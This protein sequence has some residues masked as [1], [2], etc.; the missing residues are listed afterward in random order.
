[1]IMMEVLLDSSMF[2]IML[3]WD[4][5]CSLWTYVFIT[6]F[7]WVVG[8]HALSSAVTAAGETGNSQGECHVDPSSHI[9]RSPRKKNLNIWYSPSKKDGPTPPKRSRGRPQKFHPDRQCGDCT[10]W[11]QLG[12]LEHLKAAHSVKSGVKH[13]EEKYASWQAWLLKGGKNIDLRF[14]S[15]LCK[16]C[17]S[18]CRT[19]NREKP[20][21]YYQLHPT[22]SVER[23]CIVCHAEATDSPSASLCSCCSTKQ[24]APA[25]WLCKIQLCVFEKCFSKL[26]NVPIYLSSAEEK[27]LC[28]KHFVHYGRLE[29]R[30]RCGVCTG[31]SSSTWIHVGSLCTDLQ[32]FFTMTQRFKSETPLCQ[33]D[34]MCS[35]CSASYT[36]GKKRHSKSCLESDLLSTN[37]HTKLKAQTVKEGLKWL[38]QAGH[39]MMSKLVERY[40]DIMEA[41]PSCDTSAVLQEFRA[42]AKR[43]FT[44]Q[45]FMYVK[46]TSS[47]HGIMFYDSHQIPEKIARELYTMHN[48]LSESDKKYQS[49]KRTS[50]KATDIY[51]MLREHTKTLASSATLDFRTMTNGLT[52]KRFLFHKLL[53]LNTESGCKLVRFVYAITGNRD[54]ADIYPQSSYIDPNMDIPE[55]TK[56]D[57]RYKDH[58]YNLRVQMIIS[59]MLLCVNPAKNLIQVILG[60][61]AFTKGL[62]QMGFFILNRL[63]L[64]CSMDFIRKHGHH[65]SDKRSAA[66]EVVQACNIKVTIDNLIFTMKMAKKFR[67]AIGGIKR[68]LNLM[69]GQLTFTTIGHN[70]SAANT[71]VPPSMVPLSK[72]NCVEKRQPKEVQWRHFMNGVFTLTKERL[73]KATESITTSLL[74]GLQQHMPSFTPTLKEVIVYATV[75]EV[76]PKFGP[77]KAYLLQLKSDLKL[78]TIGYPNH[79]L[80]GGDQQVYDLL[81]NIKKCD[82]KEK[83]KVFD[84]FTPVPGD[85]H[86][87]KTLAET[88]KAVTW[89]GGLK[90]LAVKCGHR[91]DIYQWQDIHLLLAALHETLWLK[92]LKDNNCHGLTDVEEL[93]TALM[94]KG[95]MNDIS[96]FWTQIL[97]YLNVYM[98][99]FFAIRTGNWHLRNTAVKQAMPIFAAFGHYKYIDLCVDNIREISQFPA[100]I[101]QQCLEGGWTVSLRGNK[102]HN[103]ALD[104]CHETEINRKLKNMTPRPSHFR[105]VELANYMA[106]LEPIVSA[107]SENTMLFTVK[108]ATTPKPHIL[109]RMYKM[110]KEVCK[111]VLFTGSGTEVNKLHNIFQHKPN[112]LPED[113]RRNLVSFKEIGEERVTDFVASET[114]VASTRQQVPRKKMSKKK[115]KTFSEMKQTT[116]ATQSQLSENRKS[117][118]KL[119]TIVKQLQKGVVQTSKYP[120]AISTN[121]GGLYNS[122]K[123]DFYH[124]LHQQDYYRPMFPSHIS[125]SERSETLIIIDFLRYLHKGPA[126]NNVTYSDFAQYLWNVVVHKVGLLRACRVIIA[127]DKPQYLPKPRELVHD[128]RK[129]AHRQDDVPDAS[130][131]ESNNKVPHG[132]SFGAALS[133]ADYKATLIQMV[134]DYFI[135]IGQKRLSPGE[136]LTIDSAYKS[137]CIE[138]DTV[139]DLDKNE[140]GEADYAVWHHASNCPASVCIVSCSDTDI[141]AYGLAAFELGWLSPSTQYYVERVMDLDYVHINM[142]VTLIARDE[143]LKDILQP[144]TCFIIVY[145]LAG[146]D[147]VSSFRYITH[148]AMLNAF[149]ENAAFITGKM[150]MVITEESTEGTICIDVSVDACVRLICAAYFQRKAIQKSFPEGLRDLSLFMQAAAHPP[151]DANVRQFLV[152]YGFDN[153]EDTAIKGEADLVELI[154]TLSFIK[155]G[156]SRSE[157][158]T[159]PTHEELKLHVKRLLYTLKLAINSLTGKADHIDKWE[160]YGYKCHGDDQINI[161]WREHAPSTPLVRPTSKKSRLHCVCRGGCE[162]RC[163]TCTKQHKACT[164]YCYCIKSGHGCMNPHNGGGTCSTCANVH[165]T[166][167]EHSTVPEMA[168]QVDTTNDVALDEEP[169]EADHDNDV[170]HDYCMQNNKDEEEEEVNG[171]DSDKKVDDVDE[172]NEE[173]EEEDE[174]DEDT[175]SDAEDVEY[176]S[177]AMKLLKLQ[178]LTLLPIIF[179]MDR[180]IVPYW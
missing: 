39:F 150:P 137:V 109:E 11:L 26:F 93:M 102:Y 35:S 169:G 10:I 168:S 32:Q 136:N 175:D 167:H 80:L 50:F 155:S 15:C 148:R 62:N 37:C 66:D 171:S 151:L 111:K 141:W 140:I 176:E 117:L 85:W 138:K 68:Q 82:K 5:A 30:I 123:S 3:I 122:K 29:Q 28:L 43:H 41:G 152:G 179:L 106:Y 161:Q 14:D 162:K 160:D 121:N 119:F 135:C 172:E 104:E 9:R 165:S 81:K 92:F 118:G 84:F 4:N 130:Q 127:I 52:N 47:H 124:A 63:G 116:R 78:Q 110:D 159:M 33:D 65:W 79:I 90:Q 73:T 22:D 174:E 132:L 75:E 163:K 128:A 107:V 59:L 157:H 164:E 34:W 54:A 158:N 129:S 113:T 99:L 42:Y 61:V 23:H 18:D 156:G 24:W 19:Q 154:R 6:H 177:N 96:R 103:I 131:I 46:G 149:T 17:E 16:G 21:Y 139:F 71:T 153:K 20:R 70:A 147:Y 27:N 100:D 60:M 120:L 115:L 56:I 180:L 38:E 101:I 64:V 77:L 144:A 45:K 55:G 114:V 88:I 170:S 76:E 58:V 133:N 72:D 13:P 105:T 8:T 112:I 36:E 67:E 7:L 53:N 25:N 48:K 12:S 178:K 126:D 51:H 40:T 142:G 145:I 69:T 31:S 89:D 97:H 57:P 83:V 173:D 49:L 95:N 134:V 87:M 146:C 98:S 91:A 143:R 166:A 74:T 2:G 125:P 108:T 86:L 44:Q 1:M 94:D